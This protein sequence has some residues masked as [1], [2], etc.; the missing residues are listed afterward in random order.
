LGCKV[1]PNMDT[2]LVDVGG[3]AA[4]LAVSRELT[5]REGLGGV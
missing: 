3:S 4:D 2:L 5:G 1:V